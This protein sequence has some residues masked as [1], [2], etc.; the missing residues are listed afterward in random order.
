MKFIFILLFSFSFLISNEI[1]ISFQG[2]EIDFY[3]EEKVQ[4][5]FLIIKEGE[6]EKI[7]LNGDIIKNKCF[8]VSYKFEGIYF[9]FD[10][11][12]ELQNR[13]SIS[14]IPQRNWKTLQYFRLSLSDVF[15][16]LFI[17]NIKISIQDTH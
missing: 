6:T 11:S 16:D 10:P 15:T 5:T 8:F 1:R 17:K 4:L 13:R 14:F 7:C 3:K 2:G 9:N 12:V